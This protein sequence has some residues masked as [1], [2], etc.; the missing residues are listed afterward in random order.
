M[1]VELTAAKMVASLECPTVVC[2]VGLKV[3]QLDL[4]LAEW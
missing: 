2:S 1:M 3:D 4:L